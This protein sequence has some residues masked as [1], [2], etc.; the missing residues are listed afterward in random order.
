MKN[1]KLLTLDDLYNFYVNQNQSYT[2]NSKDTGETIVVHINEKMT[3]EDDYDPQL[4]LL[5]THLQSCHLY[6]NRNTSSISEES[7]TQ[8]IP[9]FY[10][11]PILGKI[12]KLED[13]SYDFAGHDMHVDED[14]N[15]EYEE[16]PVGVIPES[17]NAQLVYDKEK[18]K[19]Y[20]EVDGY[21]FEEYTRAA[22]ILREKGECKVSVEISVDEMSYSAKD[23][24]LNIEKF[25]FLGVT[26]LGCT[27]DEYETPIEEGMYGSNITLAEFS[28][29]NNSVFSSVEYSNATNDFMTNMVKMLEEINQKLSNLNINKNFEEGGDKSLKLDELL[30]KYGKTTDDLD[31]DYENMTDEELEAK[32]EELFG[33]KDLEDPEVKEDEA[34]KKK[35]KC[36]EDELDIK[37]DEACKKKNKCSED[38]DPEVKEDE[39]CK[40]K[41]KCDEEDPVE[42]EGDLEPDEPEVKE[43]EACKKKKKCTIELNDKEYVFEVALD[44]KIRALE[45]IVNDTYS[46]QDNAYYC[47]KVYENYVVMIDY[48]MGIAYRQSYT[49]ENDSYSLTG[50]RVEVYCTYLTKEEQAAV[51]E[52]QSNY[53]AAKEK[54]E[55]YEAKEMNAKR[56]EIINSEDYSILADNEDFKAL[57]ENM[58]NYSAEELSKEADLILAKFVKANKNF[59]ANPTPETSHKNRSVFFSS[60]N[61]DGG[62][63]AKKPYGGFYEDILNKQKRRK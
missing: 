46:E 4:G 12:H 53:S 2:F 57:K 28:A 10:N 55:A 11:R 48:W 20:L 9:S 14:G 37:E 15:I 29:D 47:V 8:A 32:F 25:H 59:S 31:F 7:M 41:K 45:T 1:K 56:E 63:K 6:R 30:E 62:E 33:E 35:K 40:K 34:C 58:S 51:D 23:K 42:P 19:T 60:T 22:D 61:D 36:E 18:D 43:D 13:G 44:D 21:I 5:K 24:V 27:D 3:F 39:A 38:D 52:L 16:I 17:C 26:I 49:S 50:D 54:L